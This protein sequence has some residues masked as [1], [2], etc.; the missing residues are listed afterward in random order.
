MPLR[1]QKIVRIVPDGL[2][3]TVDGSSVPPGAM[4]SLQNLIKQVNSKNVTPRPA[5]GQLI[6]LPDY[7]GGPATAL[8][9]FGAIT[10]GM[11][12]S[13]AFPGM[14][15][16]FAYNN[17]NNTFAT[18][19]GE[20]SGNLPTTQ[21]ASGE[22]VP[23]TIAVVA[24]RVVFTHPG[25]PGGATL[26]PAFYPILGS[27]TNGSSVIT[28]EPGLSIGP[29]LSVYGTGI[30]PNTVTVG[31][32]VPQNMIT[33][34][35]TGTAL[36]ST[37]TVASAAGI[38]IGQ[39]A[40]GF[41]LA[42]VVTG[43]AGTTITIN[44]PLE[45]NL[46]S[47]PVT[48]Y[49]SLITLSNPAT[50]TLA[51]NFMYVVS[52]AANKFGWLDVSGF[53]AQIT[54]NTY[55]GV[56]IIDGNPNLVGI[57]PGMTVTGPNIPANTFVVQVIT[58]NYTSGGLVTQGAVGIPIVDGWKNFAVGQIVSGPGI[59]QDSL[60]TMILSVG[61]AASAISISQPAISTPTGFGIDTTLTFSGAFVVLSN[62]ATATV[63]QQTFTVAGGTPGAPLWG[64]GDLSINPIASTGPP[65]FV[66]QFSN[67]AWFGVNTGT[68]AGV[69]A[70]DSGSAGIQTNI[71]QTLL[72]EDG[73]P[74]TAGCGLPLFNQLGGIIQSLLVFQGD[75]NI[76]Q[77]TG[78]FSQFNITVNALLAATGTLAP[79]SIATTPKG[80]LFI[81]S[82][83]MR[84]I[85]FNAMVS[86]P[87]GLD[88]AGICVPFINAVNPSRIAAAFNEDVYRVTVT[89]QPPPSISAIWGSAQRT[90]EFWYHL[91]KGKWSGPHTSTL[92]LAAAWPSASSFI[93]APMAG[94]GSLYR[95]DPQPAIGT[96]YVE[97]G[98]PLNCVYQTVLMPDNPEGMANFVVESSIFIG[99][100]SGSEEILVTATD[101]MGQV[102][103][104][105]YVAIG[106]FS[107]PAQRPIGWHQPLVFRQMMITIVARAASVSGV[108]PQP[109][110]QIG[111]LMLRHQML[112]YQLAYPV[113]PE[114][115][116]GQDILGG[117][118][119]LGP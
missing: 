88:G 40:L 81:A 115:I 19:V 111:A 48:F 9:T 106:P 59:P 104:Q 60:P 27:T 112:G 55:G 75:S 65:V 80:L 37:F 107:A 84:M 99:V 108:Q 31:T 18:I 64:A 28:A 30:P 25:F 46:S 113:S 32:S 86:D 109:N 3:D 23:P 2:S 36:S 105:A 42:G 24:G 12:P 117:S 34:T 97:F 79:N 11:C 116:L 57:Q 119:V 44:N 45:Q 41:Y 47:S 58:V 35:A 54:G 4:Y 73:V 89:W 62:A 72:F 13:A 90:D 118:D 10:Y 39:L 68:T 63:S 21:P 33:T 14:D 5:M 71:S 92:D 114:F 110:L 74:V 101:D 95:S 38:Q 102:L 82:D 15:H 96:S 29:G 87:I 70:S 78:D 100:T 52:S 98:V 51:P 8:E 61:L 26:A 22:W 94:R 93:T 6:P 67:R 103:D 91:S 7:G 43:I 50:A 66:S 85:D 56:P 20:A 76:R 16:P 83:G 53:S 1:R 69:Q 77:I 17:L 49:Q